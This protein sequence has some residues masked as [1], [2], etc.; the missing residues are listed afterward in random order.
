MSIQTALSESQVHKDPLGVLMIDLDGFKSI[1]DGFGH[2]CGDR[3][4]QEAAKTLTGSL[5]PTDIVGRWGGDEFLAIVRNVSEDVLRELAERCVALIAQT[6]I[7]SNTE[8]RIS[9]SI[10]VGAV[11]SCLGET[12]EGLIQRADQLMYRS[13]TG[14]RGRSTTE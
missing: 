6:S 8:R 12:A 4:L 9:L 13:K 10:S 7:P 1:N 14:G 5:R 2:N 11:L 3:A